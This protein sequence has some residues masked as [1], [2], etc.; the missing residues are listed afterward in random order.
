[1]LASVV[2]T[3]RVGPLASR[4]RVDAPL[5]LAPGITGETLLLH[6]RFESFPDGIL[7]AEVDRWVLQPGAEV[8]MGSQESGSEGPSAYL[9]ESGTLTLRPDAPIAV[10]RSGS[11]VPATIEAGVQTE[12]DAG[13]RSFTPFG[14]TVHWRN[15]GNMPVRILEAKVKRGDVPAG[16][17]GIL[18][19]GVITES[20]FA[21]PGYPIAM[22]VLR[23]TLQPGAEL[24][25]SDVPG[26][27]MLKVEAGRLAAIDV[28]GEG[29]PLPPTLVGD[30]TR[31]LRSFP[32]GRVFR[33]ST[34]QPVSLL[35]VTIRDAHPLG[36]SG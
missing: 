11:T 3:L 24:G 20:P 12:L 27:E 25:A 6:A 15:S 29:A 36:A 28:D 10:T 26:L 7:A 2:V 9:I 32:P 22:S 4:E 18:N 14:I 13:D 31:V 34:D 35:L 23:V 19:Y 17:D 1:V 21:K 8:L 33:N 5:V 30:A 16:G